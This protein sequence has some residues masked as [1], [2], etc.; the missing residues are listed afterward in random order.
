[1]KKKDASNNKDTWFVPELDPTIEK[2]LTAAS[3]EK[4]LISVNDIRHYVI[5]QLLETE[6]HTEI[7]R[8]FEGLTGHL[9]INYYNED[10][11]MKWVKI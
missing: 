6:N 1:M 2:R 9:V 10:E 5:K 11:D 4:V 7:C 3:G 8:A